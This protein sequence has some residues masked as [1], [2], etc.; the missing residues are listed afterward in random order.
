METPDRLKTLYKPETK[1]EG[2]TKGL[3]ETFHKLPEH[4]IGHKAQGEH[5]W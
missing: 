3:T 4:A 1:E 5:V 2:E